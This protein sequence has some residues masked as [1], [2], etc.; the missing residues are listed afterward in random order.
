VADDNSNSDDKQR[1]PRGAKLPSTSPEG[2]RKVVA[3]LADGA[4][5]VSR[6]RLASR[7][8]V[9]LTGGVA[10]ALGSAALYGFLRTDSDKKLVITERG[11]AF[12]SDDAAQAKQAE[13]EALMSTG[14]GAVIKKLATRK[15]AADVVALRLQEDQG[16]PEAG[17]LD[18]ARLLVTAATDAGLVVDERFNAEAI[19]D[20]ID[21]VGEPAASQVAA[22]KAH[23]KPTTNPAAR[24]PG[25]ATPKRTP[26]SRAGR[27][28][29]AAARSRPSL[30]SG[31]QRRRR[32]RSCSRSTQA[33][34]TRSRSGRSCASCGRAWRFRRS[35]S[36]GRLRHV[37]RRRSR[38]RAR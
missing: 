24:A 19:E 3:A 7:L 13:R 9:Q 32:S 26:I 11:L 23:P 8:N 31:P 25:A 14:F 30:S 37:D 15:A 38:R 17:A 2:T 12:L 35:P 20:T 27:E 6:E 4:G 21:A 33:S 36:E 22:P 29:E 10:R 34:W 1:V 16:L 28:E 5:P 18:R